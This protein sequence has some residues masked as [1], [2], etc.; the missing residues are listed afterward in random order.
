[1]GN[2]FKKQE[3]FEKLFKSELITELLP[4]YLTDNSELKILEKFS[5]FTTYFVGFN[6]NR[7]N[8]YS[9]KNYVSIP[10]RTIDENLPKFLDNT[11]KLIKILDT[12]PKE[13]IDELDNSFSKMNIK[14]ADII[15]LM[16]LTIR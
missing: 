6:E 11:T 4:K 9:N 10:Y 8:I 15:Q 13:K 1:M 3:E 2:H 12:L 16:Q 14:I 5:K 7:K